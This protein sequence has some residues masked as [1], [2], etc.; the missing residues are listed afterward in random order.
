M[1]PSLEIRKLSPR[2]VRELVQ[3]LETHELWKRLMSIIPKKLEK[4]NFVSDITLENQHKY[5]SEHFKLIE[6]ASEKSRRACTEILLDEWGT[7]GRVRPALGHLLYLLKKAK[8]FRA[9]DYVAVNLL[10]QQKPE[11]PSCGPEALISVHLPETRKEKDK[12]LEEIERLLDE[13]DY[14]SSAMLLYKRE[15]TLETNNDRTTPDVKCSTDT[16][17]TKISTNSQS[18]SETENRPEISQLLNN[19]SESNLPNFDMMN[20]SITVSL[21]DNEQ[22]ISDTSESIGNPAFSQL[23]S[24][25]VSPSNNSLLPL[26]EGVED[27]TDSAYE[28]N[29]PN[30][31]A[32]NNSIQIDDIPNLSILNQDNYSSGENSANFVPDFDALKNSTREV[33]EASVESEST[34]GLLPNSSLLNP[35]KSLS[36]N[37]STHLLPISNNTSQNSSE[38]ST[39]SRPCTSPLPNLSLNTQLPHFNYSELESATNNF[40]ENHFN[41]PDENGRFLGSGAFGSVF[42][43]LGLLDKPVAVKKLILGDVE[44]VNIDDTVTKQF[45]N[46]VE[47]LSKYEHENL[48]SLLGYSCNGCTYC[49]MYEFIPGGALKERLQVTENKLQW[50]ER[51]HISM[52][53][54]RAVSY[55]HTAFS[56]PLIHRDIKSANILLDSRNNPKLCDFGLIKLQPS[57][58]TNTATTVFGT[59]AYMAPEAFRGDISVKLDTFSFGV[60][61][62]E[63][64]TSLPPMDENREGSDL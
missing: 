54:A 23:L 13:I 49:L 36:V 44:V 53:T 34:L 41:G 27:N 47:V 14:P 26:T 39:K 11:R 9:A 2:C 40:N 60:V 51:L 31:S 37:I 17:L 59:S 50:K 28:P 21:V 12:N 6:N 15:K 57:Q 20:G 43:A 38:N 33:V 19:E 48:L 24:S 45:R 55:L 3:I 62:L 63:L 35:S 1:D 42:L 16:N 29:I 8:L 7:S 22:A 18:L 30:L 5:H 64:L 46:E 10:N 32:L 25:E 61:L 58:H 52:G 4:Y 56:T